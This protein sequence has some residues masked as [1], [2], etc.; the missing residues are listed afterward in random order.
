MV[1]T[2]DSR[3]RPLEP[4][5]RRAVI[6]CCSIAFLA[7][8]L[9]GCGGEWSAADPV[10]VVLIDVDTLRPDFLGA[11]GR[12]PSPTPHI[13][14]LAADGIVFENAVSP[15]PITG[16]S[17]AALFTSRHPSELGL[18]N[19][20]TSQLPG[21]VPV[22]AEILAAAGLDTGAVIAIAPIRKQW[23]FDRGFDAFDD[24]LR[25]SWILNADDVL[26]QTL[27]VLDGLD[28]PFFL[29]SHLADPHEPYN[30]HGAVEHAAEVFVGGEAVGRVSTSMS[31]VKLI[32]IRLGAGVNELEIRGEHPFMVRRLSLRRRGWIKP[33]LD[34]EHPPAGEY[35]TEYHAEITSWRPRRLQLVIQLSDLVSDPEEILERYAR[36]VAYV[37]RH[38]GQLIDRLKSRGLY[39]DSLILFTADHGEGLGCHGHGGHVETLYDCMVRV[40]LIV[41]PPRAS[42]W[43]VGQRRSDLAGLVDVLPT[44]LGVLGVEPRPEMRG[45]D[46]LDPATAPAP[47]ILMET[48]RP[49]AQKTLFGLRGQSHSIIFDATSEA[50]EFYDLAQDPDQLVNRFDPQDPLVAEWAGRL[51]QRL[52]SEARPL[53]GIEVSTEIDDETRAM[54]RSLGYL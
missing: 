33:E 18:V 20:G 7:L 15:S 44:V 45:R 36:E 42:G 3:F 10:N 52:R 6:R 2:A 51:R 4:S 5:L 39:E 12:S 24:R 37:D 28:S 9:L 23:G 22:M 8:G 48:H 17:H 41:K 43:T 54:L 47:A 32:D 16:P 13:D 27:G 38:V 14:A 11:Y 21:E 26:P 29:W 1:A 25:N 30:A 46:L 35:R 50:W 40:P 34:P 31:A 49:Q 53:P 19:N